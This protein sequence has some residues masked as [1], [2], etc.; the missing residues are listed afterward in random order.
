MNTEFQ[1]W[2]HLLS[3]FGVL[4]TVFAA[5]GLII[6]RKKTRFATQILLSIAILMSGVGSAWIMINQKKKPEKSELKIEPPLVQVITVKKE[7]TDLEVLAQGTVS[8]RTEIVLSPQISGQV[9]GVS[10]ALR[11]GGSFRKGEVLFEIDPRDYEAALKNARALF[12]QAQLRLSIEEAESKIV[13]DEWK[14]FGESDAPALTL[15]EPQLAE[16]RAKLEAAEAGLD[17]AKLNLER[18]L[19]K[20]PFDGRVKEK[21]IDV[22]QLVTAGTP[23][24]RIYATDYVEVR[25]PLALSEFKY[26]GLPL[27]YHENTHE[28]APP[29]AILESEMGDEKYSWKS[30]VVRTEGQIDPKSRMIYVVARMENPYASTPPLISGLFVRARIK[31]ETLDKV[32]VLPR[33]VV[34]GKD[35]TL[36]IDEDNHL[37]F[38]KIKLYRA[39]RERV[40]VL[41]GLKEG[42]RVCLTTL[43]TVVDDMPVRVLKNE[44]KDM[45]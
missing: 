23:A 34:R 24:V 31:G 19:V 33:S 37:R 30:Q 11:S 39:E 3:G 25:L 40:I 18:T 35:T 32:I 9:I 10:A 12:T 41:E 42:E 17:Q 22:G 20:T 27:N 26:L 4:L 36:V 28:I 29:E 2:T 8:P 45:K 13:R 15:R 6:S 1:L 14:S 7:T 21:M 43:E 44:A 16:A 38:R 5:I